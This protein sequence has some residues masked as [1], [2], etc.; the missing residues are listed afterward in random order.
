MEA[1]PAAP[2]LLAV[3]GGFWRH[4]WFRWRHADLPRELQAALYYLIVNSDMLIPPPP[5]RTPAERAALAMLSELQRRAR[6]LT[7]ECEENPWAAA[8]YWQRRRRWLRRHGTRH[9]VEEAAAGR[10]DLAQR[11]AILL[12]FRDQH[13]ELWSVPRPE[14]PPLCFH[15][16][17]FLERAPLRRVK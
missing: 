6:Y 8:C 5:P 2:L 4:L 16:S 10:A 1:A 3:T 14:R 15:A 12:V 11:L 17:A 13:I 9:S 7:V